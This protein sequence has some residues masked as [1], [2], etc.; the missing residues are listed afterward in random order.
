MEFVVSTLDIGLDELNRNELLYSKH[1][2]NQHFKL[3]TI[4]EYSEIYI[5]QHLYFIMIFLKY[6]DIL[7]V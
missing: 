5:F 6:T 1:D 7:G 4:N 2:F 3:I